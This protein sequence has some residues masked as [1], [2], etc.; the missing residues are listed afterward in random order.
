MGGYGNNF[1]GMGGNSND[2]SFPHTS[3]WK[4]RFRFIQGSADDPRHAGL[5]SGC[6]LSASC[7]RS[8]DDAWL[9]QLRAIRTEKNWCWCC[10]DCKIISDAEHDAIMPLSAV[11]LYDQSPTVSRLM[12][13]CSGVLLVLRV[14]VR[15]LKT[16]TRMH[17][18]TRVLHGCMG[19]CTANTNTQKT[20]DFP[21]KSA[22]NMADFFYLFLSYYD[23]KI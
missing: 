7:Y 19:L 13:W 14:R 4:S 16:R 20:D 10:C 9:Q 22:K 17:C 8:D 5:G 6:D 15:I 1:M 12:Q 11:G 21:N 2:K 18:R 3:R 23:Y